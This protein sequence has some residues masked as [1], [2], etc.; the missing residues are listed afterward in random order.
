[1]VRDE[2]VDALDEDQ[3]EKEAV[4]VHKPAPPEQKK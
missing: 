2:H 3:V 1:V 4:Q